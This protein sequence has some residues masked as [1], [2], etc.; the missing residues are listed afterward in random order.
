MNADKDGVISI[1]RGKLYCVSTAFILRLTATKNELILCLI[2][3]IYYSTRET[4]N[5][6][7]QSSLL[8]KVE[9]K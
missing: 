2:L 4:I 5:D 9:F 1:L 7:I 8:Y 6:N 3:T